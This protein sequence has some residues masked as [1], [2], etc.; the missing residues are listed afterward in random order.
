MQPYDLPVVL[1]VIAALLFLPGWLVLRAA[2]V[3]RLIDPML[4]PAAALTTT[5]ALLAPMLALQLTI[6][7]GVWWSVGWLG[8]CAAGSLVVALRVGRRPAAVGGTV[9]AVGALTVL[10]ALGGGLLASWTGGDLR[11]DQVYHTGR[12]VKLAELDAPTFASASR[13]ADGGATTPYAFPLLHAAQ[14]AVAVMAR[15]DPM[16]VAWLLPALLVPT[17]MLA[18]AGLAR[19]LFGIPSAG[20]A[21]VL[22]WLAMRVLDYVP[23]YRFLTS[24][25]WPGMVA[26]LVVVPLVCALAPGALHARD[27]GQRRAALLLGAV[28]VLVVV[29][30]HA[31]YVLFPALLV[32]GFLVWSLAWGSEPARW[33]DVALLC[34]AWGGAA[35]AGLAALLPV[36]RDHAGSAAA[37]AGVDELVRGSRNAAY[38]EQL[39]SLWVLAVEPLVGRPLTIVAFLAAAAMALFVPRLRATAFAAA[40]LAAVIACARIPPLTEAVLGLGNLTVVTRMWLAAVPP[41]TIAFTG[42]LLLVATAPRAASTGAPWRRTLVVAGSLGAAVAVAWAFLHPVAQ[43]QPARQLALYAVLAAVALGLMAAPVLRRTRS[44][45]TLSMPARRQREI[46]MPSRAA[47]AAG[48]V[49]LLLALVGLGAVLDGRYEQARQRDPFLAAAVRHGPALLE[50]LPEGAVVLAD[51]QDSYVVPAV[52]PVHVVADY[53]Y[54]LERSADT[55]TVERL[56]DVRMFLSGTASDA[57]RWRVL[58][59]WDVD[60][61]LV[62]ADAREVVAWL[63]DVPERCIEPGD[64]RGPWRLFRV[65]DANACDTG[66]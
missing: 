16:L 1:L 33:R 27:A 44:G 24:A 65:H 29:G 37:G 3:D 22:A 20:L 59:R 53:K 49:A 61:V 26:A 42:L 13:L 11:R 15:V 47:R 41:T 5:L 40:G 14:A 31:N 45:G 36:L 12:V 8:L 54:W 51:E 6:G 32:L 58:E 60:A 35:A 64:S 17:S 30:L 43:T 28:G 62:R 34:T 63:S 4:Q 21:A 52:A 48:L 50:P 39:D 7:L 18:L 10:V 25:Q 23:D 66:D 38:F 46:A 57:A 9:T 56:E 19:V 2:G 55:R